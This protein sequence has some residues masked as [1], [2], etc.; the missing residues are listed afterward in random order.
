MYTLAATLQRIET[1]E[2]NPATLLQMRILRAAAAAL[3]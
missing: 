3:I 1:S 2:T